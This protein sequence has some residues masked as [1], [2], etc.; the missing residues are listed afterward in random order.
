[1]DVRKSYKL[2]LAAA[3]ACLHS[4]PAAAFQKGNGPGNAK[5]AVTWPQKS[6]RS[7]TYHVKATNTKLD[8]T[9][10]LSK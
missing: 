5:Y 9:C 3:L 1:M 4:L 8:I 7:F 6:I 10:L 2:F